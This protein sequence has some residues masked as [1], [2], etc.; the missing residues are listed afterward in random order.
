MAH[1]R[2][3][4]TRVCLATFAAIALSACVTTQPPPTAVAPPAPLVD[5]ETAARYGSVPGEK[6]HVPP[7]AAQDLDPR[8]VRQLV[9][10]HDQKRRARW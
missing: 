9:D 1:I 3:L 8:N 7:V 10:Y 2:H 5:P 6:H 4:T